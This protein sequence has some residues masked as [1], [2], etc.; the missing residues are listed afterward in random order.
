[1][2][3][4]NPEN[5]ASQIQ[6][7]RDRVRR[8]YRKDTSRGR[9]IKLGEQGHVTSLICI[10]TIAGYTPTQI[11]RIIGISRGKVRAILD[12]TETQALMQDTLSGLTEAAAELLR[13]YSIEAV[14]AIADVMRGSSDDKMIL[15]AASEILDRSGLPKAS[16]SEQK[17]H[18]TNEN[19]T[20]IA[21]DG[22][23]EQLREASPEIREQAA[24]LVE[25]LETLLASAAE[26][27]V[28]DESG[29]E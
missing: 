23:V 25:Q 11:S 12:E 17:V 21:D 16:R 22:I 9:R 18:K 3:R 4:S 15:Q 24:T 26:E 28:T 2:A 7:D 6:R 29:E 20:T 8:T 14:Q 13:S 1:M 27:G 19:L 5:R 10:F